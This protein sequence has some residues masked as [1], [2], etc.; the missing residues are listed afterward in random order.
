[1]N[2][3]LI[4]ATWSIMGCRR[5]LVAAALAFSF[6]AVTYADVIQFEGNF[7]A[8]ALNANQTIAGFN[9]ML[10]VSTSAIAKNSPPAPTLGMNTVKNPFGPGTMMV[11]ILTNGIDPKTGDTTKS[12]FVFDSFSVTAGTDKFVPNVPTLPAGATTRTDTAT[13]AWDSI[14]GGP[15]FPASNMLRFGAGVDRARATNA[16]GKLVFSDKVSLVS[17]KYILNDN[18]SADVSQSVLNTVEIGQ[19]GTDPDTGTLTPGLAFAYTNNANGSVSLADLLFL[20][21]AGSINID[22]D[23]LT[24]GNPLPTPQ[25]FLNGVL[26]GP[27]SSYIVPPDGTIQFIFPDTTDPIFVAQGDV[28]VN[29]VDQFGF[30]YED[31]LTAPEPATWIFLGSTALILA[32]LRVRPRMN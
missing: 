4:A 32:L 11:P 7:R 21:S 25:V 6:C 2:S 5:L 3:M 14:A 13:V 31:K 24:G 22:S 16:F 30:T 17:G 15:T 27:Q 19:D 9:L 12:Q 28:F 29:G 23:N 26:L 20:T 1:M 8:P 10:S 18:T